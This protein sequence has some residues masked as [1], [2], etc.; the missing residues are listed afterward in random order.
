[1]TTGSTGR[2]IKTKRWGFGAIWLKTAVGGCASGRTLSGVKSYGDSNQT[3]YRQ[4]GKSC[5]KFSF[6]GKIF[7]GVI[8]SVGVVPYG[9]PTN[10]DN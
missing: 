3:G 2:Y 6:H 1:M 10:F 5:A 8:S 4:N 7:Q 9:S